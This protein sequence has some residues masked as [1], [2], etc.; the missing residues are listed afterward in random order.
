MLYRRFANATKNPY[1]N[2]IG[3][4][5]RTQKNEPNNTHIPYIKCCLDYFRGEKIINSIF[6]LFGTDDIVETI[7]NV[8]QI[9]ALFWMKT[10]KVG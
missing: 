7:P 2:P 1:I 6:L 9:L 10:P 5:W 3:T 8:G 4:S